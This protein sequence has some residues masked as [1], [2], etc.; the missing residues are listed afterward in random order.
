MSHGLTREDTLLNLSEAAAFLRASRAKMYRLVRSGD[1][2]AHKVGATYVFYLS[3]LHA[4][5]RGQRQAGAGSS[6]TA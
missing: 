2:V 6:G 1:L 5:V 4:Y 3:D